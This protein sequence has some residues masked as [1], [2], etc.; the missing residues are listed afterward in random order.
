MVQILKRTSKLSFNNGKYTAY[1]LL[2]SF[3]SSNMITNNICVQLYINNKRIPQHTH[4]ASS[5]YTGTTFTITKCNSKQ[6]QAHTGGLLWCE[7]LL[8]SGDLLWLMNSSNSCFCI[9]YS[10][11]SFFF[12]RYSIN[13][14]SSTN[15]LWSNC[16]INQ[17]TNQE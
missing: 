8:P 12:L 17:H 9:K 11:N 14:S 2:N 7:P 10:L 3:I 4:S 15:S 13:S 5:H 16:F 1:I 6:H